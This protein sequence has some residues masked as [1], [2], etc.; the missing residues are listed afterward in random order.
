MVML[1]LF[2]GL[3]LYKIL[4]VS[5]W[6]YLRS[7]YFHSNILDSLTAWLAGVQLNPVFLFPPSQAVSESTIFE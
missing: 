4:L 6:M 3:A 7:W 2:F 1:S 5:G